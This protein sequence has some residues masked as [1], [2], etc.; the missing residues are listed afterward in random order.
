MQAYERP[1]LVELEDLLVVLVAYVVCFHVLGPD[2][3]HLRHVLED[4]EGPRDFVDSYR[5]LF[6][7]VILEASYQTC[8][9]YH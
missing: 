2:D 9:P 7:E 3:L 4:G 6:F 1:I 5:D 8:R